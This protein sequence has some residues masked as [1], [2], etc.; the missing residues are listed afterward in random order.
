[1]NITAQQKQ[2]SAKSWVQTKMKLI[3]SQNEFNKTTRAGIIS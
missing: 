2:N 1:M 3:R